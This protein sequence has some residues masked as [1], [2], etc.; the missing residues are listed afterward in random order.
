MENGSP[1]SSFINLK[2][3]IFTLSEVKGHKSQV[4]NC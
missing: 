1:K 2:I 3:T 4:V